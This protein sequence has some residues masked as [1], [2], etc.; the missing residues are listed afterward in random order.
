MYTYDVTVSHSA[1]LKAVIQCANIINDNDFLLTTTTSK[2]R[3]FDRSALSRTEQIAKGQRRGA[4][5]AGGTQLAM[6]HVAYELKNILRLQIH[7]PTVELVQT[8]S[9]SPYLSTHLDSQ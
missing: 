3:R 7:V 2:S 4:A 1:E 9:Q 8:V 6:G 5:A